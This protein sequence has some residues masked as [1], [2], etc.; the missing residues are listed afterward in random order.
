MHPNQLDMKTLLAQHD[1]VYEAAPLE[2]E[3]GF[4]LG[5][6]NLGAVIDR[7]SVV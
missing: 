4:L 5:N 1:M 6:G 2:W 3:Q 7:K